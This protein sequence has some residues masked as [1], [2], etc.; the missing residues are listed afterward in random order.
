MIDENKPEGPDGKDDR[1]YEYVVQ[2]NAKEL[3]TGRNVL[4]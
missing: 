2:K 3:E 1:S 4:S